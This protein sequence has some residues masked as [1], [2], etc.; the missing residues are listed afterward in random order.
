MDVFKK[1]IDFYLSRGYDMRTAEYFSSG[2]KKILSV[3][4][5][6]DYSLTILFDN[7]E[8]RLL[9]CKTFLKRGT[10]FEPFLDLQNFRRVYLD[11]CNCISWD[12]DPNINSDEVWSNKVDLC[13]DTCYM[14]SIP[15]K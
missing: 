10:V 8:K 4:A 14:D 13:P 9:D 5:N 11:D 15:L 1:N 12:I 3:L 2:R 7:N 6:D